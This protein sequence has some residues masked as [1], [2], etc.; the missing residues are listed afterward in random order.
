MSAS[1]RKR[2]PASP[3]RRESGPAPAFDADGLLGG[4]LAFVVAALLTARFLIP[5]EGTA[6]GDTLWLVPLWLGALVLWGWFGYR[7]D[8]WPI[9]VDW[10]DAA[11]WLLV[12]GQV[13]SALAVVATGGDK[14]AA[15]NMAWEW[16]GLGVLFFLVRQVL[17]MQAVRRQLGLAIIAIMAAL[18]GLGLWQHYVWYPQTV[19]RYDRVRGEL[20]ALTAAGRPTN[21]EQAA[22][23]RELTN[24]LAAQGI[25][26]EG[27]GRILWEN[28]LKAST[29]PFGMFALANT[30]AGLLA[31]WLIVAV[32]ILALSPVSRKHWLIWLPVLLLMAYCLL[33]TKSRTAWVGLA[34]SGACL[35][36]RRLGAGSA[37]V[38]RRVVWGGLALVATTALVAAAVRSGGLDRE[39]LAEAPKSLQYRLE[40]W[41]G[42][43]A[44]IREHPWLGTGPG[45]F[46]PHYLQHK[47]P[48]SSEEIADPHNFVLDVWANG[49]I[50]SLLGLV[51]FVAATVWT[52][53]R[54][55]GRSLT[56]DPPQ[57]AGPGEGPL[58]ALVL[59][60][61]AA[62]F[63]LVFLYHAVFQFDPDGRVLALLA[64]WILIAAH[65]RTFAAVPAFSGT[66]AAIAGLGLLIHLLGAGG[67]AMP[68]VTQ[69]LLL[70]AALMTVR[71][72]DGWEK[73]PTISPRIAVTGGGIAA[74]LFFLCVQTALFPILNRTSLVL[75]GDDAYLNGNSARAEFMYRQA[76]AADPL[77][78]EPM[79]RLA[80][81]TYR[82]W[83]GATESEEEI[84]RAAER[85]ARSAI[86]A[87][88]HNANQYRRLGE[89]FQARFERSGQVGDARAAVDNFREAVKRYPHHAG[90]RAELAI[91][92]SR[93]GADAEACREAQAALE[94][95]AAN[96]EAGHVDKFLGDETIVSLEG[97]LMGCESRDRPAKAN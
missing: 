69:V 23:I 52:W 90:L 54:N 53:R 85:F 60:G 92:Y 94:L 77:S 83:Q 26:L 45:N 76:A 55:E 70:F 28:R 18:S 16:V 3:K 80:D 56:T 14:R 72:A 96:R 48:G 34:V 68:A 49:G 91:A 50:V 31:A 59:A 79:E 1:K 25:P 29:E 42:T 71:G 61:G 51:A 6:A 11:L 41:T 22:R 40:Y 63:V 65:L 2:V 30:F 27:T 39:V 19:E 84:F 66:V 95:E 64:G 13:V 67:I 88:P 24:E 74:V 58:P 87:D 46:R 20:D 32:G 43:W 35:A 17:S 10:C 75:A 21:I 44:V 97:L 78:P 15:V 33:L 38:S 82:R 81:L 4:V 47:L 57:A 62:G 8:R 5:T 73:L 86:A 93:I 7:S 89:W 9:Q 12:G 36:W 37:A